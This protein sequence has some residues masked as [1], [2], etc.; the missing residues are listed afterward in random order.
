MLGIVGLR[1]SAL[2]ILTKNLV[3]FNF[4][5]ATQVQHV[6][7]LENGILDS[8]EISKLQSAATALVEEYPT[9]DSIRQAIETKQ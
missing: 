8:I 4:R 9:V 1:N 3:L 2:P 5:D 6:Y 7:S